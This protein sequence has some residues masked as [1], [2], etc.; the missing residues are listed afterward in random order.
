MK[1][2]RIV[3][4]PLSFETLL[5]G[6][7]RFMSQYFDVIAVCAD[8]ERLEAIGRAEAVTTFCVELTRKITFLKDVKALIK[9]YCFLRREK[10]DIVH[11]H[12]PKA[13]LIGMI[14]ARFA[15]VPNRLHTVAGMPLMEATGVKR[16]ILEITEKTT[17]LC[18]TRIYPN[19]EGLL[20]YILQNNFCKASKMKIIAGGSS[21]GINT[22]FFSTEAVSQEEK[23]RIRAELNIN[24]DDF[25]FCFIGRIVGDK[26]I[27]ELIK[28]FSSF[29]LST[30]HSSLKLLLVGPFEQDLDPVNKDTE[31]EIRENPNIVSVGFQADVRLYLA[32]ADVFVF[33]SYR[34]GFPNV[35]MQAGAMELPCIV[36][37]INGC[38][39]IIE[40]GVNGLL[41]PP[42]NIEALKD[43]MLLLL[44]DKTLRKKFKSNSRPMITMRY[45]QQVV[46][47]ALLDEYNRL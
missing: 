18:A 14:A 3:T 13:G 43:K 11:T 12:T 45:E 24:D 5:K 4:V 37:D 46:W 38:N 22:D 15:G 1:L 25:V 29:S 32:I 28:A 44:T 6:Q 21:N 35:V 40:D 7:L 19:S 39:E 17:C 42:K 16:R 41:V 30:L 20:K 10:P 47:N 26:G 31:R 34:E 36:S 2:V 33:P 23:N 9:L 8:R 27:N